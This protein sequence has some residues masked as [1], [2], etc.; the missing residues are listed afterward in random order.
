M[1]HIYRINHSAVFPLKI[2]GC[3]ALQTG[4]LAA[5]VWICS[6]AASSDCWA[7]PISTWIGGSGNWSSEENWVSSS[8]P[9]AS[10]DVVFALTLDGT[11]GTVELNPG[12]GSRDVRSL[13][14]E[15]GVGSYEFVINGK[16]RP[17][18]LHVGA[19]G[20]INNSESSQTFAG[21]VQLTESQTWNAS[22]GDIIMQDI[23]D[24][25]GNQL[26]VS[27]G[28][29]V[30][31]DGPMG[32]SGS[33][34]KS[35]TGTLFVN[36]TPTYTG[37]TLLAGGTL[38]YGA[39][40]PNGGELILQGGNLAVNNQNLSFSSFQLSGL[41]SITLGLD[42]VSQN[43][44]FGDAIYDSGYL[45]IF[46]W[47]SDPS[48]DGIYF[49][50]RPD[51]EFLDNVEFQGYGPGALWVDGVLVPIPEPAPIALLLAGGVFFYLW[52]RRRGNAPA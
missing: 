45:T 42:G 18:T 39:D 19:G 22:R 20:I 5:L 29:N 48:S 52:G 13:T 7:Q 1:K 6:G 28:G 25:Q 8:V 37:S 47:S 26:T 30:I 32:G 3:W 50:T 27:G 36:V 46:N 2:R 23:V 33:V 21:L 17:K 10:T 49:T 40:V 44:V 12:G 9:D 4:I 14:F 35:G 43:L 51:Q 38:Q 16:G 31:I 11:G 34:V 41:A 24:L 15:E